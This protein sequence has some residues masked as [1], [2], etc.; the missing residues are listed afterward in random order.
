[1]LVCALHQ[2][3]RQTDTQLMTIPHHA[4]SYTSINL[5]QVVDDAMRQQINLSLNAMPAVCPAAGNNS[6]II[7]IKI[8]KILS[9][10]DDINKHWSSAQLCTMKLYC[11][12]AVLGVVILSV[13]LYGTRVL[14]D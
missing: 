1:M 6:I 8:D 11:A 10:I 5:L 7:T 9:H 13:C 4:P 3:D 2:T 12:F 14:C